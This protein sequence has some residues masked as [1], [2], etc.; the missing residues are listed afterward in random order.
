MKIKQKQI[1][2]LHSVIGFN[3]Y[4]QCNSCRDDRTY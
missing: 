4:N 2:P 3:L 1:K